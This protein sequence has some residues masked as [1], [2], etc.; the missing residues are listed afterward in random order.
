MNKA[1]WFLY[2]FFAASFVFFVKESYSRSPQ[3]STNHTSWQEVNAEFDNIFLNFQ[4]RQFDG[5]TS[6]PT[7]NDL[8]NQSISMMTNGYY[9][10]LLVKSGNKK[11]Y[12]PMIEF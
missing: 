12:L 4:T 8:T 9:V 7:V 11:F 2:G 10:N 6:T 1:H 5:Y 3:L